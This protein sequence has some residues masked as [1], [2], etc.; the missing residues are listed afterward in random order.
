MFPRELLIPTEDKKGEV[1]VDPFRQNLLNLYLARNDSL[2]NNFEEH[3]LLMNKGNVDWRPLINLWSVLE[4]LSKYTAKAGKATQHIGKLF[5]EVASRVCEFEN[6]N[7]I[8]DLWRRTIMKF[9]SKLIGNRDYTLFEVVHFG[10]RLPGVLHNFGPVETVSV[11]NW[12][13]V[14]GKN[15]MKETLVRDRVTNLSK[16]EIFNCRGQLQLPAS[17]SERDFKN[18][19]FYCFW[20]LY[21]VQGT[22]LRKRQREKMLAVNGCG[23]PRQAKPTHPLHQEYAKKTLYAYA[24][25]HDLH[26]TEYLDHAARVFFK[27]NGGLFF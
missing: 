20:R 2:L 10:L 25:C 22:R 4:Y 16:L 23:W 15:K 13:T 24:P 6:E 8:H 21:S 3:I 14:K 11:S 9:Y 18:I 19:S 17:V 5:G 26:G 12:A 1:R 7:G 27:G